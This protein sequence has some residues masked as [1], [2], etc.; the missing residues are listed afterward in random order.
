MICPKCEKEATGPDFCGHC[1]TP[2]KEKCSECG[3]MEPMGRKF[4]H[5]EYDE[6]EKIWKQSSAMR[7]IN[8]IP[9]VALAAVFTVVALSSL[10]VAYFYNQYLLPLPIPDGIKALIVTMVLIIPTASII[11]TIF[12]AGIKLADKKREEFFLKNPQYEK[13]R[14]R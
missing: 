9:V 14:K 4:C 1:A 3:E 7:T 11:T 12:I 10:L 13:F 8:A 2:L 5:A 6:F